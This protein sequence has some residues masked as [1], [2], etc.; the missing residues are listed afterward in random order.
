MALSFPELLD[1]VR[2]MMLVCPDLQ[3]DLWEDIS[4]WLEEAKSLQ[5]SFIASTPFLTGC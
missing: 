5:V 1:C 3:R 2:T 4:Y